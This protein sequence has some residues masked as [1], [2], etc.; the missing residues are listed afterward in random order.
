MVVAKKHVETIHGVDERFAA[1]F[2]A[3]DDDFANRMNMSGVQP[4]FEHGMVGIHQ[5]HAAEDAIDRTHSIRNTPEGIRLRQKNI[6]LMKENL[7]NRKFVANPPID[8]DPDYVWG[9]PRVVVEHEF[10]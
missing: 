2:C 9:D 10:Y 6:A 1:G 5:D 8:S 3:E 7:R 4:V